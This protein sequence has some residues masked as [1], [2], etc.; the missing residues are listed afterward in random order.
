METDC[1]ISHLV[2]DRLGYCRKSVGSRSDG[3]RRKV[4]HHRLAY[5]EHH[6][7]E[8]ADIEG[9]EVDHLCFVRNCINPDH[10]E[11]VSKAENIRRVIR[12]G[13]G[14][15][16]KGAAN[17]NSKLNEVTVRV[18]RQLHSE[19]RRQVDIAA[20]YGVSQPHISEIVLRKTWKEVA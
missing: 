10:L 13:R 11:A 3:T 18:I 7:L 9:L 5:V 8:F 20:A 15:K 4:A 1:V 16:A 6:G 17:G 12:A 2:P 14:N 19:G